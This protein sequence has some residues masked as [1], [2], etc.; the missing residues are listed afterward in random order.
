MESYA[1][2][3]FATFFDETFLSFSFHFHLADFLLLQTKNLGNYIKMEALLKFL[4]GCR[5]EIYPKPVF[6]F[7]WNNF[8][9][10]KT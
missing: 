10:R 2:V 1:K 9:E 5:P 8:Q 4:R 3:D 7:F 6:Q